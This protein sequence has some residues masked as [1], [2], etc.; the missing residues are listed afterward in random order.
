MPGACSRWS[1]CHYYGIDYFTP[2][3]HAG[4]RYYDI[5]DIT[6]LLMPPAIAFAAAA[7]AAFATPLHTL[8]RRHFHLLL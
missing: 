6:I 5:I 7:F 8:R 3:Y 1:R 2:I 4:I